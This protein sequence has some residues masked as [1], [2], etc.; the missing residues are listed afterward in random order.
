M[1]FGES[2]FS[3][4][5]NQKTVRVGLHVRFNCAYPPRNGHYKVLE[6]TRGHHVE[7]ERQR[8]PG[9]AGQPHPQAARPLGPPVGLRVAMS[10]LH[11]LLGCIY[12]VP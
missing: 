8:L 3:A 10:I 6:D 1:S 7:V 5:F 4:G 2:V 12:I 9:R 11:R